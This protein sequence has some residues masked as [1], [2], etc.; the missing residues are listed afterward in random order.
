MTG[1]LD[2]PSSENISVAPLIPVPSSASARPIYHPKPQPH[3][4]QSKP[5]QDDEE[6]YDKFA[7]L[8]SPPTPRATP[9]P[10]PPPIWGA[11]PPKTSPTIPKKPRPD[12][13][14][15]AD[16]GDFV[17]VPPS[18][19]P[20]SMGFS[21]VDE[22]VGS[23]SGSP[24][25]GGAGKD[26]LDKAKEA[27]EK[28]RRSVLDELLGNDDS[29]IPGW[30]ASQPSS[31]PTRNHRRHA[32]SPSTSLPHANSDPKR[33][34]TLSHA[35]LAPPV[36]TPSDQEDPPPKLGS[37]GRSSSYQTLSHILGW[38][39]GSSRSRSPPTSSSSSSPPPLTHTKTFSETLNH[40]L[41]HA[42]TF[43]SLNLNIAPPSSS[44]FASHVHTHVPIISGA[45]GF[46]VGDEENWDKGYSKALD[47]ELASSTSSLSGSK[48]GNGSIEHARELTLGKLVEKKTGHVELK[49]RKETTAGVLDPVLADEI[50]AYLP[51]LSRLPKAWHLLYSLDQHGISLNTLYS[52]CEP[53]IP[54]SAFGISPRKGEVLVVKDAGDAI[55]GV[56]LGESL[57]GVRKSGGY[58]G[59]GES[60]LFTFGSACGP[61]AQPEIKVFKSTHVNTYI[62]LFTPTF[63]AFGGGTDGVWGMYVDGALEEGS[64]AKCVTFNNEV[65]C[66]RASGRR[67][68]KEVL[69]DVVGLEVWGVGG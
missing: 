52:R 55:F 10:T 45:P 56:F 32:T 29:P 60:F 43:P 30:S 18:E 61:S 42:P 50:R 35:T 6:M 21:P 44:P 33:S 48:G 54:S 53:P 4:P 15:D 2:S 47:D 41:R 13:F 7:T 39:A 3:A 9:S 1:P 22:F 28:N 58:G 27:N 37:V 11:P 24:G 68:G 12:S 49:G 14:S 20:L 46:R 67:R 57:S 51:A 59:G 65:L 38:G 26:W 63:M 25:S 16:F 8:F 62:S 17:S 69:F 34:P 31:S 23:S 40:T 5:Q 64:S 19:D 66:D 36:Y